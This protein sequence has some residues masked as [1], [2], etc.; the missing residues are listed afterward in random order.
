[1]TDT[2]QPQP[3]PQPQAQ[4]APAYTAGPAAPAYA[5]APAK[6]PGKT[7]G[8][9]GFILAFFMPLIGVI[10][11]II[12]LVQS[13]KAGAK[14]GLALAAIIVGAV[15][16]ILEVILLLTV[17]SFLWSTGMGAAEACMNGAQSVTIA[18]Q[19]VPCSEITNP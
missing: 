10:L 12:G 7:I 3:E 2:P 18:G 1:M 17:F 16:L 13:R 4:A 19:E 11:G 9:V 5:P 15:L 14:N 8:I 6:Q